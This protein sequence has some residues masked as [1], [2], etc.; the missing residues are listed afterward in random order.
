MLHSK[1]LLVG[2]LVWLW[3]IIFLQFETANHIKHCS[4]CESIV[5]TV[6]ANQQFNIV[7][8]KNVTFHIH[9][10]DFQE[11]KSVTNLQIQC[12]QL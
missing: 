8:L 12:M 10:K 9:R 2:D 3:K 5:V 1:L 4:Y 7:M 6:E 11:L